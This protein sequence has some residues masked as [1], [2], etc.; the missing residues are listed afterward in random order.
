MGAFIPALRLLVMLYKLIVM[1]QPNYSKPEGDQKPDEHVHK[2]EF[3]QAAAT[4]DD[5]SAGSNRA[6]DSDHADNGNTETPAGDHKENDRDNVAPKNITEVYEIAQR[7]ATL[8]EQN[9]FETAQKELYAENVVSIEPYATAD[10]EKE[11]KGKQN[12]LA[13]IRKFNASV[14]TSYGNRVSEPLVAG[15]SIA[16]TLFMNLKMKGKERM[17]M[18]EICVYVVKDGKIISE[19]FFM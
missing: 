10:Y 6:A 4:D 9:E 3:H 15:S 1:Q 2:G 16:F 11:T 14:E 12:V 13:K 7:L 8:C 17:Q 19:Q 18:E 5:T